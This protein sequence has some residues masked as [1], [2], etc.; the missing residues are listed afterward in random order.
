VHVPT[1]YRGVY[2]AVLQGKRSLYDSPEELQSLVTQVLGRDI[3]SV[4]QR[5]A[6]PGTVLD[7]DGE[8]ATKIPKTSSGPSERGLIDRG[9]TA[10]ATN[11]GRA[12]QKDG[13][14]IADAMS[15]PSGEARAF[16]ERNRRVEK[17]DEEGGRT[18]ARAVLY[19][20]LVE[21]IDFAYTVDFE[22]NVIVHGVSLQ[23]Q[24]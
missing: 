5:Q 1:P 24:V 4:H 15:C 22:G 23:M 7:S 16:E 12:L 20:L 9:D 8:L 19:H 17:K 10:G 11:S 2:A 21:G 18:K 13:S 14:T 6:V 3:R